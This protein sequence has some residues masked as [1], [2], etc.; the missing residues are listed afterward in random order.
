MMN[1]LVKTLLIFFLFT[2]S[3]FAKISRKDEAN[4]LYAAK[5]IAQVEKQLKRKKLSNYLV[6]KALDTVK[7][8]NTFANYKD[9]LEHLSEIKAHLKKN[10]FFKCRKFKTYKNNVERSFQ[11]QVQNYC[12]YTFAFLIED[13]NKNILLKET[14]ELQRA[15]TA[16]LAKPNPIFFKNLNKLNNNG[17]LYKYIS[18]TL[19]DVT[20]SEGLNISNE[21]YD[22]IDLNSNFTSLL[23]SKVHKLKRNKL[24]FT[25]EFLSLYKKFNKSKL[26]NKKKVIEQL[27]SFHKENQDYIFRKTAWIKLIL[28]GKNLLNEGENVL[29]RK[30]FKHTLGFTYNF[31]TYNDSIFQYLWTYVVEKD[32]KGVLKE[33]EKMRLIDQ[34]TKLSSKV[35][36]WIAYS[37][38]KEGDHS[39]ANHLFKL[40]IDNNPLSY[41]AIISQEFIPEYEMKNFK[42]NFYNPKTPVVKLNEEDFNYKLQSNIKEMHIWRK[43]KYI[44]KVDHLIEYFLAAKPR[45]VLTNKEV[46]DDYDDNEL[47]IITHTYFLDLFK[48]NGDFLSKFKF[49]SK[50][51]DKDLISS[52][53]LN[54]EDMFPDIYADTVKKVDSDIDPY[55]VLSIIRQ[56]SAFNPNASSHVGARGLMQLMPYTAKEVIGKVKLDQLYNPKTNITA[57]IRYFKKLL[58]RF[59]GNLIFA[60]SS[61]NAGPHKVQK[62]KKNVFSFDDPLKTIEQIPY[63]ETRLYVKL[64]YRNFF[65]Y[66]LLKNNYLLDRKLKDTFKVTEYKQ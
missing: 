31:T 25:R 51:I 46:L 60:L 26:K 61:Y 16:Y 40:I 30:V 17:D 15:L 2:Q 27:L 41:Y 49:I 29:A 9:E 10:K 23:Q 63:K 22:H 62:W 1:L 33:I 4:D 14:E 3:S 48:E 39:I 8:S 6:K 18:D 52:K 7:K 56:E 50:A 66:N 57:G 64:I 43:L 65:F 21:F 47:L 12:H 42:K 19:L 55:L 24:I 45:D 5:Y 28:A 38:Y 53:T 37:L 36:F 44:S 58:K 54:I 32:Y 35:K 59:N 34:F 11:K 20:L 13:Q